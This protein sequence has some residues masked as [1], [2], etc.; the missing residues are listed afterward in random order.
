MGRNWTRSLIFG[1]GILFMLGVIDPLEGFPLVVLGMAAVYLGERRLEG[2]FA[3]PLLI[4]TIAALIGVIAML[5]ITF[6][7][8]TGGS[9]GLSM[10]W[11]VTVLPYPAAILA[12][13]VTILLVLLEFRRRELEAEAR[14][15]K[16]PGSRPGSEALE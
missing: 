1:G 14:T 3:K 16:H 13:I 12:A 2:R 5:G 7:G 15:Q 10:W 4:E 8:G 6:M 9:S 11:L